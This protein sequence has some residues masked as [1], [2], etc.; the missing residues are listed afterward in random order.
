MCHPAFR[1]RRGLVGRSPWTAA[2]ALVRLPHHFHGRGSLSQ[3][4][5]Q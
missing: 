2:D 5:T 1:D 4:H 3:A